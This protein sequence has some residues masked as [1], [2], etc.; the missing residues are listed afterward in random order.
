M[1]NYDIILPGMFIR[2]DIAVEL[3]L[4][5]AKSKRHRH[6]KL[7]RL[8]RKGHKRTTITNNWFDLTTLS[9]IMILFFLIVKPTLFKLKWP[10]FYGSEKKRKLAQFK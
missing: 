6:A 3:E 8:R 9:Y 5:E 1:K 7:K 4:W 2:N 10:Q